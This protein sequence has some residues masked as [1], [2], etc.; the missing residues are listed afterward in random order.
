MEPSDVIDSMFAERLCNPLSWF[1][2]SRALIASARISKEQAAI[3]INP[4]EKSELEN[5]CSM[6]YGLTI[7]NLFKAVWILNKYG[8]PHDENWLP[9][10]DF[11]KEI[12]THDLVKL[13]EK[14]N[15][16]LAVEYKDS[17]SLLSEAIIWSGRYPC[18]IQGKEGTIVRMHS[19]HDDAESIYDKY[20]KY[21]TISR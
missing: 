5:V 18:S 13:A 12:K 14:I 19:I 6:L 11:P 21:F 15:K 10:A 16:K 7:E 3:L 17:L 20:R 1:E 9:E 8:P 2:H 4:L